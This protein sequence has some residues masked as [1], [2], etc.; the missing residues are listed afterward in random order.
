VTEER[1]RQLLEV[2]RGRLGLDH[3]RIELELGGLDDDTDLMEISRSKVYE[4]ARLYVAPWLL[5]GGPPV[6]AGVLLEPSDDVVESSLVH[7]LL[8]CLTRDLR[9][10]TRDDLEGLVH[11]DAH[12]ALDLAAYR[13]EERLVDE[14]AEAL[15]RA[16]AA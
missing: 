10:I 16:F 3:W 7:E 11:R 6:P 9:A 12:T 13:A 1:L 4:R 15:V 8:H 2:W 5:V 14:L